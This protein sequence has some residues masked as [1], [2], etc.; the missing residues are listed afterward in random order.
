MD[1]I[2]FS[3]QT[4]YKFI[5]VKLIHINVGKAHMMYCDYKFNFA[6]R[7]PKYL[8]LHKINDFR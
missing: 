7:Y 1:A 8:E 2:C 4:T 5:I 6:F 3:E